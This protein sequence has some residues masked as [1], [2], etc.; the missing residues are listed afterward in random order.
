MISLLSANYEQAKMISP[1]GMV[2][3]TE[4]R[5]LLVRQ[6]ARKEI[7]GVPTTQSSVPIAVLT[8]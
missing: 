6:A 1:A 4:T 5:K 2:I 8:T 7:N 3:W